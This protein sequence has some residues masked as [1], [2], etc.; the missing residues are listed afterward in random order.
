MLT[1]TSCSVVSS[2]VRFLFAVLGCMAGQPIC[3][4][5][6]ATAFCVTCQD[7]ASGATDVGCMGTAPVC[8]ES[9]SPVHLCLP[10][11]DTA[12]GTGMDFGCD[13]ATPVCGTDAGGSTRCVECDNDSHCMSG[14]ICGPM[15]LESL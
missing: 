8:D 14:T 6:G 10:C 9:G 1:H 3:V 4:G 15:S 5:S 11:E 7:D 12:S 2:C 13:A